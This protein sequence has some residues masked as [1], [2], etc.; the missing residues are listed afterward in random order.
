MTAAVF[1][2]TNVFVYA[3]DTNEV[4]KHSVAADCVRALWAEHRGRTSTLVLNEFYV[5]TTRRLKPGLQAEDAW[6]YV[7][8]LF[9]WEPQEI[10]SDLLSRAREIER[11][12]STSWWDS[13]IVAAAKRQDCSLLLT[14]DLQDGMTFGTVTVRN[15]F[16]VRISEE[17]ARYATVPLAVSR[18]RARGRPRK[19]ATLR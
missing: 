1:V 8:A 12:Y 9:E 7:Q 6:D 10:T 11:R 14:E 17:P 3:C 18:H 5:T 15:P 16:T 13:L 2:D 19:H 4:V